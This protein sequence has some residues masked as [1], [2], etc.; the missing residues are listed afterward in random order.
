MLI[1][2]L[3]FKTKLPLPL[4]HPWQ[5]SVWI[6]WRF[7]PITAHNRFVAF[8]GSGLTILL[9]KL[10]IYGKD[11]ISGIV[12]SWLF[13]HIF[14]WSSFNRKDSHQTWSLVLCSL[15]WL[16]AFKNLICHQTLCAT[17]CPSLWKRHPWRFVYY[18]PVKHFLFDLTS[19][20]FIHYME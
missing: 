15:C 5:R 7:Q 20:L 3:S 14:R 13:D 9:S 16:R 12:F 4:C 11:N 10:W 18:P 1:E 6:L 19:G 8:G 17:Y 2:I